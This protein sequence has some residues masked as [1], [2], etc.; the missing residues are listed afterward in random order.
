MKRT[1]SSHLTINLAEISSKK[2]KPHN[3]NPK[4]LS[5]CTSAGALGSMMSFHQG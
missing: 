1:F 3:Q 4:L 2:K 5:R